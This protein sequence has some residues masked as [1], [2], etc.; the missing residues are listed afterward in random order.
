MQLHVCC[1][2]GLTYL[3]LSCTLEGVQPPELWV[4]RVEKTDESH[5]WEEPTTFSPS[6]KSTNTTMPFPDS[7]N[8][9][10]NIQSVC[11][12]GNE[13]LHSNRKE[14]IRP[15]P[16]APVKLKKMSRFRPKRIAPPPP[17]MNKRKKLRRNKYEDDAV[18]YAVPSPYPAPVGGDKDSGYDVPMARKSKWRIPH[19]YKAIDVAKVKPPSPYADLKIKQ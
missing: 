1:Y 10:G 9:N 18:V 11:D 5:V 2:C 7:Q 16:V 13:I 15:V 17:K 12:N 19:I 14:T 6:P 3:S 8:G 4:D